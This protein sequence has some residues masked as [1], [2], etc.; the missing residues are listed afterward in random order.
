MGMKSGVPWQINGVRRQARESARE[1]ARRAGMSL[2]AWLDTV[3]LDS[4]LEEGVEP[5]R[6]AQPQYAP[7]DDRDAGRDESTRPKPPARERYIAEDTDWD[8]DVRPR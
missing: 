3:I 7:Y 2:G 4:A 1:A 6:L 5:A 8:E